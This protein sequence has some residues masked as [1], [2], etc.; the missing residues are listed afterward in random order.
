[1]TSRRVELH[2][3]CV[4]HLECGATVEISGTTHHALER[5][6][7]AARRG[8]WYIWREGDN[9]KGCVYC[10]DHVPPDELTTQEC[11]AFEGGAA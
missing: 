10:P 3:K 11:P 1:M 4:R 7:E 5:G 6:K 9:D 2:L 8:G